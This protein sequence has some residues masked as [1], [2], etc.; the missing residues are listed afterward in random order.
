MSGRH[1]RPP[2]RGG[3]G[4]HRQPPPTAHWV[5]PA[6]VAVTVLGAGGVGAHAAL[7]GRSSVGAPRPTIVITPPSAATPLP[8]ASTP[9]PSPQ[10][11]SPTASR[12]PTAG[13]PAPALALTVVGRVSWVEVTRAHGRVVFSGLLRHG[14]HLAYRRGPLHLVIGNAGAVRL[15]RRGLVTEPAGRP[16][17]VVRVSVG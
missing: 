3:Q 14:G 5:A 16:R 2:S 1:R 8:A 13:R 15:V 17:Q 4:R 12:Q 7:G 10:A 9:L 6:L 11:V